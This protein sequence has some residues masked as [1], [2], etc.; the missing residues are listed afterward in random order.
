VIGVPVLRIAP[1]GLRA[2]VGLGG[3]VAVAEVLLV[4]VAVHGRPPPPA[5]PGEA[6][7]APGAGDGGA[8]VVVASSSHARPASPAPP[9]LPPSS[10]FR[11][12]SSLDGMGLRGEGEEGGVARTT[13][14]HRPHHRSRLASAL[15]SAR[16]SLSA[17]AG[18]EL[19][20]FVAMS[21]LSIN[22]KTIFRFL[23][24]VL[25][26]SLVRTFGC[27]APAGKIYAINPAL[28]TLL[29]PPVGA[30][31]SRFDAFDLIHWG[32]YVSALS[33]LFIVAFP[34][35]LLGAAGFVAGLSVGE[36]VWSPQWYTYSMA[37]A[38]DGH[39]GLFTALAS[40]PLFA[41][42]LPTGAL[43]GWLLAKFCPGRG[44]C[45]GPGQPGPPPAPGACDPAR[46]WGTVTAIT[47]SSPLTIL[48]FQRWLRP[49]PKSGGGEG[50]GAVYRR[51]GS[52]DSAA[53][54]VEGEEEAGAP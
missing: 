9:P 46:L 10:S 6:A 28:I 2:Y 12:L 48:V 40:A 43:S 4:A 31:L 21:I 41:A 37:A 38:P 24:A 23:D 50:D 27:D 49:A 39:E 17:V 33:P 13:P 52:A 8:A 16:A 3:A 29:V 14:H 51:V 35:S 25:P 18:P 15:A 20:K 45:P 32:G 7:P 11:R 1:A 36:A 34:Q 54:R 5:G 30:A 22:L 47:L 44:P 19:A 42:K 53:A 26:K